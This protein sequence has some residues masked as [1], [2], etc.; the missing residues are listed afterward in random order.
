[1]KN[2][3]MALSAPLQK[4]FLSPLLGFLRRTDIRF[5]VLSKGNTCNTWTRGQH[6]NWD[7]PNIIEFDTPRGLSI[8]IQN[9]ALQRYALQSTLSLVR[10]L[11]VCRML[12][13]P[14]TPK[15]CA[16]PGSWRFP[17]QAAR[18]WRWWGFCG[19]QR[20]SADEGSDVSKLII[21]NIHS[22]INSS[23]SARARRWMWCKLQNMNI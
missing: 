17:P 7:E 4:S 21:Q 9:R 5:L 11:P 15:C 16:I 20:H 10:T 3:T 22:M 18:P 23:R 8:V 2:S 13:A 6:I 1:M 14:R 19:V 12:R